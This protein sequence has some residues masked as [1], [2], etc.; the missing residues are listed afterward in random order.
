V[1][2]SEHLIISSAGSAAI[3][4]GGG[5]Y[6]A[7]AAFGVMGVFIDFDHLADY[8]PQTGFNTDVRRFMGFF[9]RRQN[10]RMLLFLHAWEWCLGTLL[11]L[12]I[13]GCHLA[14]PYWA[15]IGWFVHL[16]L[17]QRFNHLHPFAYFFMFRVQ[18]GFKSELLYHD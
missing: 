4:A 15:C 8:W 1:D 10:Q 12:L 7:A 18:R 2:F 11:G 13:L 16:L 5:G 14:W 6:E 9:H 17:D 3:L